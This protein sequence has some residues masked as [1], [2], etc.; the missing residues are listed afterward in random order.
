MVEIIELIHSISGGKV[1][2]HSM[3]TVGA[4]TGFD[5][6]VLDLSKNQLDIPIVLF[7]GTKYHNDLEQ[8]VLRCAH[9]AAA[10]GMFVLIGTHKCI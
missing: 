4:F 7:C 3:S 8:A 5:Y 10:G 9:W 2:L 6:K 1:I